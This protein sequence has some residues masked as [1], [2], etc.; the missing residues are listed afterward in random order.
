LSPETQ[1]EHDVR[2]ISSHEL[3][4]G[5]D[6]SSASGHEK[7]PPKSSVYFLVLH[8]PKTSRGAPSIRTL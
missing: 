2:E 1:V 8:A 6:G 3:P 7:C 4:P 5:D